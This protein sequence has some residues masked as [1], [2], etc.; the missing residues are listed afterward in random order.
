MSQSLGQ[1]PHSRS[2]HS[3]LEFR[4]RVPAQQCPRARLHRRA[5]L[6]IRRAGEDE[7]TQTITAASSALEQR[8]SPAKA[9][10][11]TQAQTRQS[12][13]SAKS[14]SEEL[15]RRRGHRGPSVRTWPCFIWSCNAIHVPA[16]LCRLPLSL[17][18][19]EDCTPW[20]AEQEQLLERC[21]GI[22]MLPAVWCQQTPPRSRKRMAGHPA[23]Q[24]QRS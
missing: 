7:G 4:L 13:S 23:L 14:S 17:Q 9:A 2:E 8:A 22:S 20:L 24:E 10:R 19:L 11:L 12:P 1:V 15:Q 21:M 5:P 18:Q 16:R 6:H 3:I